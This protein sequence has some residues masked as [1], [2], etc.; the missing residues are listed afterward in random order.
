[1]NFGGGKI[2]A[3]QKTATSM[4]TSKRVR[5]NPQHYAIAK[6]WLNPYPATAG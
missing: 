3:M 1:L 4:V 5:K 2:G 6:T